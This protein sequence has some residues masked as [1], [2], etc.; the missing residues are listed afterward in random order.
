M[1]LVI[2]KRGLV[3]PNFKIPV[4]FLLKRRTYLKNYGRNK[5]FLLKRKPYLKN[6][7]RKKPSAAII[8]HNNLTPGDSVRFQVPSARAN[9]Y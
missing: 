7:R 4:K 3:W 9:Y 5:Y 2:F 8:S 1:L 6:C